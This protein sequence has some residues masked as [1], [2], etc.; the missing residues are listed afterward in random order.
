MSMPPLPPTGDRPGQPPPLGPAQ[1]SGP[2]PAHVPGP[3][4]AQPFRWP[5]FF[6]G[7]GTPAA[8]GLIGVLLLV[9]INRLTGGSSGS[10]A[11]LVVG[12][13]VHL[14]LVVGAV[15]LLFFAKWRAWGAGLLA[16]FALEMIVA[17]GACLAIA[18][19]LSG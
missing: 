14:F 2:G 4:A 1:M 16:G 10:G 6:L 12:I 9:A 3:V 13:V 18:S 11:L 19:S 17:A 5:H 8:V 7:L 15:V